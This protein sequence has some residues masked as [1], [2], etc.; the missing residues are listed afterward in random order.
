VAAATSAPA[1]ATNFDAETKKLAAQFEAM[2]KQTHFEVLGVPKEADA[3]AAKGAYL[4]AARLYHPDT[5]P[6]GAPE[7]Y[8]K[9]RA[10]VF[11][12]IVEANR[13]LSD[14]K[15]KADYLAELAAGGTG[16]K[17]D[18]AAIFAAEEHFTKGQILVKARKFPEA[19]AMLEDAIKGNPDEPEYYAWRGYAKFFLASDKKAGMQ[20]SLKDI[21]GC[22]K[23]NP[24][25]ANAYFF[26]GMMAKLTGDLQ[27]A[28]TNFKKCA[29][30]D[31][32]NIDC[33][34]ELR[35]MK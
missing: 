31:P 26:T 17:V 24:K 16:E 20:E 7:A 13:V 22:L 6:V 35:S 34:R 4:K 30:L 8:A 1:A 2:K 19:V 9:A 23:K 12:R 27:T 14:P 21:N 25:C 29:E 11:A 15:A 5:V 33:A 32:K 28:K 3:G 10:D 18:V